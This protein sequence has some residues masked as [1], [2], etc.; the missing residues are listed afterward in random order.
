MNNTKRAAGRLKRLF[1]AALAL[2]LAVTLLPLT[3]EAAGLQAELLDS[4]VPMKLGGTPNDAIFRRGTYR[5]EVVTTDGTAALHYQILDLGKP[6]EPMKAN[7]SFFEDTISFGGLTVMRTDDQTGWSNEIFTI[8]ITDP[9]ESGP[10]D[11]PKTTLKSNISGSITRNRNLDLEIEIVDYRVSSDAASNPTIA[12]YSSSDSF[13]LRSGQNAKVVKVENPAT[14]LATFLVTLPVRYSGRGNNISVTVSY[15]EGAEKRQVVGS[16]VIP[17]TKEYNEREDEDDD[18]DKDPD[19]LTPYIIVESYSFGSE[20]VDAGTDFELSM[21]LRNTSDTHTLQNIVMNVAPQGIFSV[22]SSSNTIY[23]DQLFAGSTVTKSVTINAGLTKVTDDKDANTINIKFDYQFLFDKVR[24]TGTSNETITLPVIFPDRFEISPPEMSNMN[25]VGD[26]CY[27][28]VPMVNK[29]RSSVYNLTASV[30]GDMSNPGQ[31]QYIGNL[32]AGQDSGADFTIRFDEPGEWRGEVVVTYEDTNMN[33]REAV[34]PF[35]IT[36]QE[37]N[38]GM[39]P[40]MEDPG[41]MEPEPSEP[42]DT[43]PQDNTRRRTMMLVGLAVA[44]MTFYTTVR[45]AK[46]KRSIFSDEDL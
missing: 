30:R 5:F 40:G 4:K 38:M 41:M 3:A 15:Q 34:M 24:K 46:A 45:K 28:Y 27:L 19:P 7:V 35:T 10:S 33:P 11:I 12:A 9:S 31:T 1:A 6:M 26:D 39:E 32:T 23:I 13:P 36:V 16:C 18:D 29:G 14:G 20:S 43:Q 21:V 44:V 37:M 42:V 17:N 2:A 25:F 22:S 8:D